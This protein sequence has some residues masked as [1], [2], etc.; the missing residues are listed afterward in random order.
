MPPPPKLD[1]LKS[2]VSTFTS[3]LT[4]AVHTILYERGIYPAETFLSARKY[5]FPVRQ[6]RH[7]KLCQWINDAVAAVEAEMIKST[8]ARVAVVI[9]SPLSQPLERFMF[10]VSEFPSVPLG[11][12]LTPFES[13]DGVLLDPVGDRG[14]GG[15]GG[16]QHQP[17][18]NVYDIEEQFR[19]ALQKLVTRSASLS[20]LPDDCSFT[21]CIELK[22]ES[23]PPIGHPQP[24]LP[25]QPSLQSTGSKGDQDR[26][27]GA[28]LGGV[29]T[30]PLRAVESGRL[31]MELWIE[32]GKMK[33]QIPR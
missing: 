10:D 30:T 1:N 27:V 24:W 8:V 11:E 33:D 7:P 17:D 4:V 32:E 28:D 15:G 2:L 26:K 6:N 29:R 14:G 13:E 20:P 22:D 19:A 3:F 5:N 16:R 21:I 31:V 25:T 23:Q 9:Y 18:T 12:A